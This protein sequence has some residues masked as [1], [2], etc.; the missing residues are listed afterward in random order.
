[1]SEINE[2]EEILEGNFHVILKIMEQYQQKELIL[3]NK[4]KEGTYQKGSFDGGNNIDLDKIFI[5]SIL[6]SYILHWYY[7]YLLHTGMGRME[8]IIRQNLYWP[9]IRKPVQKEVIKFD[10]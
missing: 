2:T 7:A 1:M 6:Q 9:G 8:A 3:L 5:P 10:N 4:Y